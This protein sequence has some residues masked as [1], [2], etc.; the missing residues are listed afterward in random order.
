MYGEKM[1]KMT[2]F[3]KGKIT[4]KILW[5]KNKTWLNEEHLG[6]TVEIIEKQDNFE[7][8]HLEKVIWEEGSLF[9]TQNCY[10]E[11]LEVMKMKRWI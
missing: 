7:V 10:P 6:E 11:I 4:H 5:N 8:G 9:F 3:E 1:R 2:R